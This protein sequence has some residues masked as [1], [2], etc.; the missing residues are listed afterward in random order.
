MALVGYGVSSDS[1]SGSESDDKEGCG[2]AERESRAPSAGGGG[3]GRETGR[4]LLLDSGDEDESESDP[5]PEPGPGPDPSEP[6]EG[7]TATPRRLPAPSLGPG[8][9]GGASSVFAN[10]FRARAEQSLSVLQRHV[11]L[12]LQPRPACIGGRPVCL[13]Y[14]KDGRCRFGGRCR[15]AHDS[16]LQVPPPAAPQHSPPPQASG[17][18]PGP[19]P[20]VESPGRT[21]R[22]KPGVSDTLIPPKRAL[23]D[24]E[25]SVAKDRPWLL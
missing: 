10:P 17:L 16:D 12:T 3:E 18:E 4:N 7:R 24:Y 25:A 13:A 21:G 20:P 19:D 23:R 22:R 14:R 11:P 9:L 2:A 8:E 15:F 1:E 5:E 6:A